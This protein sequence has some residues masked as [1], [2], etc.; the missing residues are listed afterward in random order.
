MRECRRF[1]RIADVALLNYGV[2][3]PDSMADGIQSLRSGGQSRQHLEQVF[4]GIDARLFELTT[5]LERE[6]PAAA[7]AL[8]LISKK[9]GFLERMVLKVDTE[10][11]ASHGEF[12]QCHVNLS[13]CGMALGSPAHIAVDAHL[14]I[15]LVLLP[16]HRYIKAY[17]KVIGCREQLDAAVEER[18]DV[19]VDF[20][21]IRDEDREVL[22]QHIFKKQ[23][24]QLRLE[25]QAEEITDL[26]RAAS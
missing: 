4:L 10:Q 25:R 23:A 8:D 2:V 20:E 3:Q 26:E 9:L 13:A 14:E 22:I 24:S 11:D 12:A 15:E 17:A 6:S 5:T 19:A 16:N 18:Y 7:E 21:Y 1:Y